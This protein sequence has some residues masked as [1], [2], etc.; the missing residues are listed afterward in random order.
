MVARKIS[1]NTEE[2]RCLLGKDRPKQRRR[3]C[4]Q[5]KTRVCPSQISQ[6]LRFVN[7]LHCLY[8][9]FYSAQIILKDMF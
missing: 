2:E 1:A 7:G 6:V 3:G 8:W 4:K 5:Q 9:F